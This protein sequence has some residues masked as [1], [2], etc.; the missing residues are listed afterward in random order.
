MTTDEL[1]AIVKA[2][3]DELEKAG[4]DFDFKAEV[5]Q[6]DDLVYVM[7]GTADKYQGITVKWQ[8]LLDIIVKKATDAKD[9][10]VSAKDIALVTLATIQGI[11]SNVS[12]MKA[13]V[14]ASEANV[15]SMKASVEASEARVTQIKTEAEQTLA[16]ATQTVTGK[17]DKTYVDSNLATK[18]DIT[19]VDGK[20]ANKADKSELA[21]ERARIDSLSTLPE[22]S[23]TGDAELIGIRIGADGVTYPNA[24]EAV[25]TQISDL[26]GDL[27]DL[28]TFVRYTDNLFTDKD[29]VTGHFFTDHEG[30]NSN[31][32]YIKQ[33]PIENGHTYK[34]SDEMRYVSFFDST[35]TYVSYSS[36]TSIFTASASGFVYVTFS[37][38]VT[39]PKLYDSLKEHDGKIAP[40]GAY[41][42]SEKIKG[43]I[44][45]EIAEPIVFNRVKWASVNMVNPS[46]AENGYIN[47]SG[48]IT[49]SDSYKTT[50]YIPV[51]KDDYI[52]ISPSSRMY[53]F[54]NEYK[55][56]AVRND[57]ENPSSVTI[58]APIDGFI[59]VT[60]YAKSYSSFQ[61]E[62]GQT[63]STYGAFK[64]V[65]FEDVYLNANQFTDVANRLGYNPSYGNVLYGKKWV[66]CG[67][68]FT[69][70]DFQYAPEDNYH[71]TDGTYAG[72]YKVYPYI[73]GNRNG[74]TIVNEAI[75]GSTMT[76]EDGYSTAFSDTR[77]TQI[78]SDAD[79]IT[80][81]FG[82]NDDSYHR[83][84]PIGTINDADNTTF[85]GAWNVVLDYLIQHHPQ[86][87]IGIIITNGSTLDIVNASI[88]IAKKWGISYLN[89]ATDNQCSFMFRSNRSD[90]VSSIKTF[91]NVHW[92]VSTTEGRVNAHPSAEA[93]E[94]EST[95][96]EAW[97][98]T[99]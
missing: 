33:I 40:Y 58:Q 63:A 86:A 42:L 62:Y 92:Y 83:N 67:D 9:E 17:A 75:N 60:A 48:T 24:G 50:G 8:N 54:Y 23:T 44:V 18:A 59:R 87:K 41:Y 71:I 65:F 21:V 37:N 88:A 25:R 12:S 57:T 81:K 91:R 80:L 55:V 72:Q 20:L 64:K 15:A 39:E 84:L 98:R 78:A 27:G 94:Y 85:Y 13:S 10:A 46:E 96:V 51:K 29:F 35:G 34:S 73:I 3:M 70:G 47:I 14:D 69:H 82:I 93:H 36:N 95:V 49:A 74:M 45:T 16:E 76:H 1:N 19:Y 28:D 77:Y 52:T 68:S 79:Y 31:Y 26:K 43:D 6:A 32:W 53:A 30:N 66:A 99:L 11:E 2:V 89:E 22:G 4:V 90:V 5:P 61:V 56:F 97:L 7:R 38:S